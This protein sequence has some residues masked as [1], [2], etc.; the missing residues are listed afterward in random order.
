MTQVLLIIALFLS[1]FSGVCYAFGGEFP[2]S[3][4][5]ITG[6]NIFMIITVIFLIVVYFVKFKTLTIGMF[7]RKNKF[8]ALGIV[9]SFVLFVVGICHALYIAQAR[10]YYLNY[11]LA[12]LT[13]ATSFAFLKVTISLD[14]KK[15]DKGIA[16]AIPFSIF[17]L[18]AEFIMLFKN[19]SAEPIVGHFAIIMLA[20]MGVILGVY[21][22]SVIF[23][24]DSKKSKFINIYI[25]SIYMMFALV[26]A[27]IFSVVLGNGLI[28]INIENIRLIIT[29]V[30]SNVFLTQYAI[31]K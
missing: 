1:L 31:V 28:V 24:S 23:C 16:N 25:M 21:H 2:I 29:I 26:F 4:I 27:T 17:W 15:I 30:C 12:V 7:V 18:I 14:K 20:F 3:G 19:N 8:R 5:N 13:I 11:L 10:L 9:S 22:F 6:S